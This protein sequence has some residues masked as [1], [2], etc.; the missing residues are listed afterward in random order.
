MSALYDIGIYAGETEL[1]EI[2]LDRLQILVDY[3]KTIPDRKFDLAS[4]ANTNKWHVDNKLQNLTDFNECGTVACACG[5]AA[6][7]PEF[8][9]L[10]FKMQDD[11]TFVY[12]VDGRNQYSWHAVKT[13]FGLGRES[14]HHLFN[15]DRYSRGSRD[16]VIERMENFITTVKENM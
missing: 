1:K 15:E 16:D 4:W 13:L 8:N 11:L 9:A 3:L 2:K 6:T 5:H 10:G 14:V 12:E 7:I